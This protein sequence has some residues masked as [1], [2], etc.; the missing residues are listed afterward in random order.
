VGFG[1]TVGS[2]SALLAIR[3]SHERH[4][5]VQ[6]VIVQNFLPKPGT[7]MHDAPACDPDE[8]LHAIALARL[9]LGGAMHVQAPPNLTD[10]AGLGDLIA[11]GIDDW[12]GVS[13]LTADHVNPERPWPALDLLR[14][15]TEAAGKVLAPRLT[16]YPE[17]V[18]D[19]ERWL[20]PAVRFPVLCANDLEG[21]ARDDAWASGGERHA[22]P[23]PAADPTRGQRGRAVLGGVRRRGKSTSTRS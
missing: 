13:P 23:A 2:A 10:V 17:F 12:G 3:D 21:L 20:D 14:G 8:L 6:E 19:P 1:E 11:A 18:R 7:K 16:V 22:D 9:V 5:H 4:G 15:A